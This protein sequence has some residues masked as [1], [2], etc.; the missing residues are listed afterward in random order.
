MPPP[1]GAPISN[2]PPPFQSLPVPSYDCLDNRDPS[3]VDLFAAASLKFPGS[4]NVTEF[5]T[6]T[7]IMEEIVV[8]PISTILHVPRSV[9]SLLAET[10][11]TEL[12][13]AC[14]HNVWGTNCLHLLPKAILRSSP[15]SDKKKR[16]VMATL[17]SQRLKCWSTDND[18]YGLWKEALSDCSHPTSK[19]N[20]GPSLLDGSP[21]EGVDSLAASNAVRALLW[22]RKGHY[23]NAIRALES[24]GFAAFSDNLAWA[25][26]LKCHP[27]HNF[28]SFVDDIPSSLTADKQDVVQALHGFHHGSSPGG[29]SLRAQHLLDAICGFSAPAAQ[30]CWH[31]LTVLVILLLSGKA[32]SW[33]SLWLAGAP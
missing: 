6:F 26:L 17:I 19:R 11:A 9:R 28:P 23:S 4:P 10:L 25:E 32:H 1:L 29:S 21:A 22:A 24:L 31:A 12:C 8:S 13:R 16:L 30:D 7:A 27:S 5:Q 2:T 3:S 20:R 18:V 15:V 33:L 14:S